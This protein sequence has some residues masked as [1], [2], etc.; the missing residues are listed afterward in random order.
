MEQQELQDT[1]TQ[2][3]KVIKWVIPDSIRTDHATHMI[4]QQQGSEFTF[5]FFEAAVPLFMGPPEEQIA[6]YKALEYIEAKCVAKVV[7]SA[8][9]ATL[10]ANSLIENLNRYHSMVQQAMKGQENAGAGNREKSKLSLGS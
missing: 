5:L 3:P 8:E 4:V 7:M 1:L 10:G 6:A 9:N 2:L